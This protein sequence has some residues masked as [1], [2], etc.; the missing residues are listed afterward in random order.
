M[1]F[2]KKGE[3]IMQGHGSFSSSSFEFLAL[4]GH[5]TQRG[6]ILRA[7]K[8]LAWDTFERKQLCV[9]YIERK[10]SM[11]KTETKDK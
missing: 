5:T 10:L 11:Q 6:G 8:L 4:L 9:G 1:F 2:L 3:A 7:G